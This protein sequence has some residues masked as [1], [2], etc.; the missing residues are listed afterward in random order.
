MTIVLAIALLIV[1]VCRPKAEH[2]LA[3]VAWAL[4]M[5]A[6]VGAIVALE[7]LP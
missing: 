2:R 5:A 4:E 3:L 1:V 6:L 7:K